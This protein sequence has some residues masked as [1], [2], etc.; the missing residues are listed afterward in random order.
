MCQLLFHLYRLL[1]TA[2]NSKQTAQCSFANDE[3]SKMRMGIL[4]NVV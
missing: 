3:K 4:L 2:G 1:G